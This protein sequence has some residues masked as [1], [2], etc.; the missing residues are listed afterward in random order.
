M[1]AVFDIDFLAER[2]LVKSTVVAFGGKWAE[3]EPL[4]VRVDDAVRSGIK[5][6]TV[7]EIKQDI[8][9]IL[10]KDDF[11]PK[12]DIVDAMRQGK[13]WAEVKKYGVLGFPKGY[14]QRYYSD[15]KDK[16]EDIGIFLI[17]VGEIENFCPDIGSHGPKFVTKLLSTV[18]L[19]DERLAGLRDF[20]ERV[21]MGQH[22]NL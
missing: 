9:A 13:S 10:A 1:K 18:P 6:K 19:D 17:P 14:A 11:L 22:G 4:W 2:D 21:H 7:A 15:L 3:V 12:S 5:G 20:V 16:L 8:V